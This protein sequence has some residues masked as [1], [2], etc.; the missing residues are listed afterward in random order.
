MFR[1]IF[2]FSF[3]A[4]VVVFFSFFKTIYQAKQ[5]RFNV[6]ALDRYVRSYERM[7]GEKIVSIADLPDF[8]LISKFEGFQLKDE[9]LKKGIHEGYVYDLR[10][11][12]TE[13]YVVSASPVGFMSPNLEFAALSDG[14]IYLNKKNLDVTADTAQEVRKWQVL[15]RAMV[16]RS[17]EAPDYL[18]LD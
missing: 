14:N 18:S 13:D 2:I 15:M 5:A 3:L 6:D 1:R 9:D 8:H 16:V 11:M 7:T 17:Q 12:G 10:E 4:A